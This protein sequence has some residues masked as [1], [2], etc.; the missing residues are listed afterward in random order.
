MALTTVHKPLHSR[1][2][3]ANQESTVVELAV[4]VAGAELVVLVA[5]VELAVSVAGAELVVLVAEVELAVSV[6]SV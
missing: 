6:V 2:I 1:P 3:T 5:E 4:S